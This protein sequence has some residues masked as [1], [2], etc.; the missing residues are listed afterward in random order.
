MIACAEE[1]RHRRRVDAAV[2]LSD[3]MTADVDRVL[4]VMPPIIERLREMSPFWRERDVR[5]AEFKP[6]YA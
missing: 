4:E 3:A 5:T 6:S 2:S 1:R